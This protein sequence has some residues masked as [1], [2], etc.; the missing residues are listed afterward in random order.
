MSISNTAPCRED[1]IEIGGAL[2]AAASIPVTGGGD[3]LGPEE[4]DPRGG[5]KALLSGAS[6]P[7][8]AAPKAVGPKAVA[9]AKTVAAPSVEPGSSIDAPGGGDD[10]DVEVVVP[11]FKGKGSAKGDRPRRRKRELYIPAIGGGEAFFDEYKAPSSDIIKRKVYDNWNML[12]P[13]HPDCE[14]TMGLGPRNT[15]HGHLEPLAFLHVWKD[16]APGPGGHRKTS[17]DPEA[18]LRFLNEHRDELAA[19]H[20]HFETP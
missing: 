3:D 20:T 16:M 10:D 17:P 19:M 7:A 5:A 12:C 18:V 15:R 13:H 2:G 9:K 4:A 14:R 8:K 11:L 1:D 6:A